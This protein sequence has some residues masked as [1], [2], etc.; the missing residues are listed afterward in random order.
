MTG[1]AGL[2]STSSTGAKLTSMFTARSSRA[3]TLA[4]RAG[5]LD[6]AGLPQRAHARGRG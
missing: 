3:S 5:E 6:V 1:L 2:V 4:D